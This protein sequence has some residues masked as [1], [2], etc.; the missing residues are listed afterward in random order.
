MA[1]PTCFCLKSVNCPFFHLPEGDYR[2]T[3]YT[4]FDDDIHLYTPTVRGS[5][6][7]KET[8]N[9]KSSSERRNSRVKSDYNLEL[10]R[11]RSKSRWFIRVIMRDAAIHADAWIKNAELALEEWLNSWFNIDQVA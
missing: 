4:K 8:M 6:K 3:Y 7:W 2:R 1:L 10:D 5:K 11:V 9:K